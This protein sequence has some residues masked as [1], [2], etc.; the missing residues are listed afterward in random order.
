MAVRL[1]HVAAGCNRSVHALHWGPS[2]LLAYAAHNAVMVYE[3]QVRCWCCWGQ[4]CN[5]APAAAAAAADGSTPACVC[6]CRAILT[7]CTAA[8]QPQMTH[9]RRVC[10]A[11]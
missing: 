2:G 4:V 9:R 6:L 8:P 3:P 7:C 11:R 5:Q 1:E 10:W